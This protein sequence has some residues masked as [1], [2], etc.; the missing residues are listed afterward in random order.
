[1]RY[2]IL[3]EVINILN[4]NSI[5]EPL[6]LSNGYYN[7]RFIDTAIDGTIVKNAVVNVNNSN[8]LFRARSEMIIIKGDYMYIN[9]DKTEKIS[10]YK[11]KIGYNVPGG[12][13]EPN[14]KSINVAVR[15]AEE[16][17][18]IKTKNVYYAGNYDVSY[19]EPLKWVAKNVPKENWWLGY[20]TEVFVGEY[21]GKYTE[22]IDDID[23]DKM[24]NTGKFVPIKSVYNKLN[25]VHKRAIDIYMN[26]CR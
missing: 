3:D 21:A 6:E 26:K 18:R 7:L 14:E 9:F 23:K 10:C 2:D 19:N 24:I 16:E 15:E 8:K 17:V 5:E 1:M 13:W 11:A 4:N 22:H 20:Y 25:P 12:G